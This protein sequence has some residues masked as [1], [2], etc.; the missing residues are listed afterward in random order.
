MALFLGQQ[1]DRSELQEKIAADL[2][3]K[4][5]QNSLDEGKVIDGVDDMRYMEG[6]RGTS[7]QGWAWLIIAFLAIVV[8]IMFVFQ[9]N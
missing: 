2:R 6:T 9:G 4:M 8:V 3:R 1:D 5:Q 7:S